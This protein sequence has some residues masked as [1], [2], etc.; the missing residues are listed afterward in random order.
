MCYVNKIEKEMKPVRVGPVL[1][2]SISIFTFYAW[3]AT[4]IKGNKKLENLKP[5][6]LPNSKTLHLNAPIHSCTQ[7]HTY[8]LKIIR[9]P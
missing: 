9:N 1:S 2:T 4:W 3:D 7:T 8:T 6:Q 5:H